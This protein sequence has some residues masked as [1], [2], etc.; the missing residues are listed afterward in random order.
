M[1]L[2]DLAGRRQPPVHAD[3]WKDIRAALTAAEIRRIKRAIDRWISDQ[4]AKGIETPFADSTTPF[5]DTNLPHKPY[6]VIYQAARRNPLR[7]GMM[8]GA[9]IWEVMRT[10]REKW[11]FSR[12]DRDPPSRTHPM[13]MAYFR[14]F[15]RGEKIKVELPTGQVITDVFDSRAPHYLILRKHGM[16]PDNLRHWHGR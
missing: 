4:L 2:F 8:F 3:T 1:P 6:D 14:P 12:P 5:I 10:R 13:G 15:D 9:F 11:M 16:L 7:A